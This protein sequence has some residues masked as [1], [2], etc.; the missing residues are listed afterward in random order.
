M[1]NRL[2]LFCLCGQLMY[3]FTT[4]QARAQ[5]DTPALRQS[6]ETSERAVRR[7]VPLTNAIQRALEAGTRDFTGRPGPNYWQ[8][9]TD[10]T[11]YASLDP[12]TQTIAGQ[13]TILIQ[14]NSNEAMQE[15]VLRLDHNIFRP[16]V[17]LGF[18]TPAEVTDG[19]VITKLVV[20]GTEVDLHAR[21]VRRRWNQAPPKIL[22]ITGLDKTVATISLETPIQPN[23]TVTLDIDWHTQLPI[24][25][26][27]MI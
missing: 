1:T 16:N 15:I 23:S 19:M 13:Q 25:S 14:N 8:L 7:D 2:L 3:G 11:I 10:Y 17:P 22:G 27:P 4:T 18:S 24:S 26:L 9:Q 6:I 20:D 5:S 12:A 21:Q